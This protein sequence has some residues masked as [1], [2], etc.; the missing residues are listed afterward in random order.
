[1]IGM[2]GLT[3]HL[4]SNKALPHFIDG[5]VNYNRVAQNLGLIYEPEW[6]KDF[7]RDME[8]P[9]G[10]LVSH[11]LAPN[12]IKDDEDDGCWVHLNSGFDRIA[13]LLF[14]KYYKV[15]S[16]KMTFEEFQVILLA[17]IVS[18]FENGMDAPEEEEF[19][20][21]YD[22]RAVANIFDLAYSN[23]WIDEF[24][25]YAVRN[26][27]LEKIEDKES[28]YSLT[29]KGI[30]KSQN[31][32][33]DMGEDKYFLATQGEAK[34]YFSVDASHINRLGQEL[35][36][37]Q[38]TAVAELVKNGY[39]ADARRV[40]LLFKS[41][42]KPG[43]TLEVLDDGHGMNIEALAN[44]FMT[45][46]TDEKVT[47]PLSVK[48]RRQKAGRKGIG[49]F[50]AQRLGRKLTLITTTENSDY[51]LRLT[52]NWDDFEAKKQI[53]EIPTR[54]ERIEK[55]FSAGT[56]LIIE[57]LRD[58]WSDSQIQRSYK[59]ISEVIQPFPLSPQNDKGVDPG[60]EA[61]FAVETD[62]NIKIVADDWT[63]FF[64]DAL[65]VIEGRVDGNGHGFWKIE[66]EKYDVHEKERPIGPDKGEP[67]KPFSNLKNVRF[68][69]YYYIDKELPKSSAKRVREKL[70]ESGGIRLY[71]NGFRVL[72]Y[73]ERYDD[74]LKLN[75][76]HLMRKILP[77]HS[78]RNFLG[79]VEIQDVGGTQFEETSSREG[80][81]ENES[82]N[83]LKDFISS[84]IKTAVLPI[85]ESR[86]K[87]KT[88]TE[89][90][91][92]RRTVEGRAQEILDKL[93]DLRKE[94]EGNT[95]SAALLDN[96][97]S[98]I[99][100]PIEELKD[101]EEA[102]IEE[103]GMM[104][105]LAS[106]GLTIGEFTHEIQLGFESLT[107]EA[108]NLSDKT[109]ENTKADEAV[110][111]LIN[112]LASI[113]SYLTYFDE[114]VRDNVYREIQP[115]EIRDAIRSFKDFIEPKIR[116]NEL[117]FK[118]EI[119]GL[120]LFTRPMHSSEWASILINFF[121]NSLKAIKRKGVNGAIFIKA[122]RENGRIYLEFSDNGDGIPEDCKGR[123]F[124]AFFT[125]TPRTGMHSNDAED[126]M[127]M[128]L[129][130]K[131][132][133]DIVDAVDGTVEV[134]DPPAGYTTC[135]RVEVPETKEIPEDAY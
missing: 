107:A 85:A 125:T 130:L 38:E 25:K 39:D 114:T 77:P 23:E 86:N 24:T 40:E 93:A 95:D 129:G 106:L 82:F 127:G 22:L 11:D 132:V 97:L 57:G 131:I 80:L 34:L 51:A 88:T 74:W 78:N 126:I 108:Q 21:E 99:S 48:F 37:K 56:R 98:T 96:V 128:G 20:N 63:M 53:S 6:I 7:G 3:D 10:L 30:I 26:G 100:I 66:S 89:T 122:G 55:N 33:A 9:G 14:D 124:D 123:V 104:R 94:A 32:W 87:K 102:Q 27:L 71:R 45:I 101:Q 116:R 119:N 69:A 43:G 112:K 29:E 133:R 76:S 4:M 16:S 135:F 62:D 59:H 111:S 92:E 113:K 58:S 17:Q 67:L 70:Q 61:T 73:G 13:D 36:A 115:I 83:E 50:A 72:P 1:M 118:Q 117:D 12:E 2:V 19:Y 110:H 134:V 121:T 44:G 46:S 31:N 47:N 54:I 103:L 120:A 8:N 64:K 65:A 90:R 109:E 79:F 81:V 75:A 41:I 42:D 18:L 5:M 91:R 105:V 49:R 52:I 60:F 15:S 84:T 68:Q 35:V 28:K